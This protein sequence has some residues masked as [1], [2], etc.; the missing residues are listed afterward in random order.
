MR[1]TVIFFAMIL[2]IL[3]GCQDKRLST[4][5]MPWYTGTFAKAQDRAGNQNI[6]LFFKTEW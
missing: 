2:F 3:S 4:T 5:D 6:M 1:K